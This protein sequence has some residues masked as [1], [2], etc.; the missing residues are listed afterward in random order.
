MKARRTTRRSDVK[1][2]AGGQPTIDAE[3]FL[4][5]LYADPSALERF[6]A[7]P[8]RE[9]DAAGLPEAS[10]NSFRRVDQAGLRLAARSA[11]YKRERKHPQCGVER[12]KFRGLR[13]VLSRVAQLLRL[14]KRRQVHSR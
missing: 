2:I 3:A 12:S 1:E 5:R 8:E 4:A 13:I 10:R 9:M 14:G 11:T 6:L 7:E